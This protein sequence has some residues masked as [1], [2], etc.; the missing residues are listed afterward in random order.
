MGEEGGKKI[1]SEILRNKTEVTPLG[2]S[3]NPN[4]G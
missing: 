3:L 4:V 1:V 2:S